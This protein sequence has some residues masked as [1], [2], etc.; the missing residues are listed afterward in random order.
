MREF[1]GTGKHAAEYNEFAAQYIVKR[2]PNAIESCLGPS[3]GMSSIIHAE[4]VQACSSIG[5]Y[6]IGSQPPESG[7]RKGIAILKLDRTSFLAESC[8]TME[9]FGD[10]P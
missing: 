2:A 4:G 9:R 1:C 7:D 8:E 6:L 3:E 5:N 10:D